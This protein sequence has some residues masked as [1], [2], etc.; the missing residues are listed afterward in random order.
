MSISKEYISIKVSE[1]QMRERNKWL[2]TLLSLSNFLAS[3]QNPQE[4]LSGALERVLDF[5]QLSAGR[6]YLQEEGGETL[7]LAAYKGMD[8]TGLERLNVSEGFS[9]KAVR[10]CSF[11]AQHVAELEDEKRRE[12]LSAKGFKVI[13]C[14]PLMA[15]GRVVG[16]MNLASSSILEFDD[17]SIDLLIALGNQIALAANNAKLYA[18]LKQKIKELEEQ[19]AAVEFFAYS[20]SH[21]LKSPAVGIY[22]LTRRLDEKYGPLLDATGKAY[23]AQILKA[24][25]QIHRLVDRINAYI[26]ARESVYNYEAV[27]LLEICESIRQEFSETLEKKSLKWIG[28]NSRVSLVADKICL[29]RVLRNLVDNA[30]KYGGPQLT[31]IRIGYEDGGTHH[32]LSVADDGVALKVEDPASLFQ[33]FHRHKTSKGSEG[34]GLGLATVKEIAEKHGGRAWIQAGEERGTTFFISLAKVLR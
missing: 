10:T 8:A 1:S 30:I 28:P 16:V 18:D 9:G 31:E 4:L 13:I 23:C 5:F 21:D 11:I 33:L 29:L 17:A 20:I 34:T 32:I 3:S 12:V 2:S 25:E 6:I 26:M 19:K 27:D 15:M 22:G 14:V 7:C 24:S